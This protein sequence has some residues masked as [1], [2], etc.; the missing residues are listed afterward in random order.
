VP[1]SKRQQ[2]IGLG[3]DTPEHTSGA[4][5][6]T[7]LLASRVEHNLPPGFAT[8]KSMFGG[9]TFLHR[10]NMLCCASRKGLM[11]RVGA[12]AEPEALRLPFA[13][14]CLGAGRAIAG[15]IMIEPRGITA[16]KDIVRWLAMARAYVE[17]LPAKAP[18]RSRSLKKL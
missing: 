13:T 10:G 14:R 1:K 12:D 16:D 9:I 6:D 18:K 11:V 17:T 15:F 8:S 7:K 3:S 5:I 2:L 4:P